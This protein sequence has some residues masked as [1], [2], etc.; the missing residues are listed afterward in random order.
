MKKFTHGIQKILRKL[1]KRRKTVV[2]VAVALMIGTVLLAG[3]LD[4]ELIPAA[5]EGVVAV[6]VNFR[7]GTT[8]EKED[9]ALK[10]WEQIAEEE[11]GCGI[12]FRIH[13][14]L[15]CNPYRRSHQEEN[16]DYSTASR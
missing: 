10:L 6:T 5:D 15:Q 9:E 8:L 4:M 1:M 12:L 7:S 2:G 14:R 3:T 11:P 13:Q 16:P